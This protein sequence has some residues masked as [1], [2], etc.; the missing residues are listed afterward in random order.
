LLLS[1]HPALIQ[2]PKPITYV[3]TKVL[4]PHMRLQT[5]ADDGSHKN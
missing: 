4:R 1:H 5:V 3:V 2:D